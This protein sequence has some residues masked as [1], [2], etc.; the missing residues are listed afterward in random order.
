MPWR[1]VRLYFLSIGGGEF[2]I[3]L[4][5]LAPEGWTY[6]GRRTDTALGVATVV[7]SRLKAA[8]I[9]ATYRLSLI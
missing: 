8:G 5:P 3:V 7:A 1:A 4:E 2:Q 6:I 9:A